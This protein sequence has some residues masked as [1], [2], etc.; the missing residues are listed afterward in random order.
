[1]IETVIKESMQIF[2]FDPKSG[3]RGGL[4]NV[5]RRCKQIT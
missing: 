2:V 1:M 4:N 5:M 3:I